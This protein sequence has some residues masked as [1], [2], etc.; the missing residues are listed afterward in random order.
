MAE[1]RKWLPVASPLPRLHRQNASEPTHP[2]G[3]ALGGRGAAA[4]IDA[5][6]FLDRSERLAVCPGPLLYASRKAAKIGSAVLQ[7]GYQL[8]RAV[9]SRQ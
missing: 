1:S 7:D 4:G 6:E 3:V 9:G 5:H 8:G 2:R